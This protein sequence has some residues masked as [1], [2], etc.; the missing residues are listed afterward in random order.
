[1]PPT[2]TEPVTGIGN[3]GFWGGS[4]PATAPLGN[5]RSTDESPAGDRPKP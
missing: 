1:M 4:T 3:E 5:R 2:I